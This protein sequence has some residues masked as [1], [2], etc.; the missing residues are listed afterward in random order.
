MKIKKKIRT[1]IKLSFTA[2]KLDP[3][4]IE[5]IAKSITKSELSMYYKRL[6]KIREKE[7][8]II[9]S[10]IDLPAAVFDSLK[11]LFDGKDI[12]FKEDKSLIAGLA[13][14]FDDFLFQAN[15]KQQLESIEREYQNLS[16]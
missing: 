2:G 1:L 12:F 13:V 15:I 8:V 9:Y 5:L 16:N 6:V 4:K 7:K 14:K 3:S 10:P 11:K